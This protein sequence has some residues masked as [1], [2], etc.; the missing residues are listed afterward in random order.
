MN[1]SFAG[2]LAFRT[3][4]GTI[5]FYECCTVPNSLISSWVYDQAAPSVHSP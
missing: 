1:K 3:F 2:E 4:Y 5:T